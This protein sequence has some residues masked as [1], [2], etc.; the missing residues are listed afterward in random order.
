MA[1][2]QFRSDD[3]IK[4][5]HGFGDGHD[6]STYA[7]P[8]MTGCSG[9]VST[10]TLTLEAASTF[11]NNDLILILQTRGT[12]NLWQLNKI[13]SGAGTTTLTLESDLTNTYSNSGASQAQ[14]MEMKEYDGL[15]NTGFTIST[16]NTSQYG[17]GGY[18]DKAIHTISGT[19]S[20]D[21]KG[22]DG[23][24]GAPNSSVQTGE[25]H[26]HAQ[27][28]ETTNTGGSGGGGHQDSGGGGGGN[29]AAGGRGYNYSTPNC[30]GGT[31]AGTA[32]LTSFA[33]G[34]GGGGGSAGGG[35]GTG[36]NG[37]GG[38]FIFAKD[39]VITGNIYLRGAA[40][41]SGG[42]GRGGGGGAGGSCLLKCETATLGSALIVATG[43]SGGGGT[44]GVGGAGSTG[45]VHLDYSKSY[46]GTTS[47]TLDVTLDKTVKTPLSGGA[48]LL[49]NF[50]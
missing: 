49:T 18:F 39:L 35:S 13:L 27:T 33:L 40:G 48:L 25:G 20:G 34:G 17:I 12:H 23:G 19:I 36:G 46:T 3:T 2:L 43:G 22:F 24:T 29:A 41:T 47:P 31:L 16:W 8:A 9:T 50:T 14:V 30:F 15:T 37:G 42:A 4:W 10:K 1:Q 21:S 6:G 28:T 11:A 5:K 7:V 38:V 26:N 44:E 45:R 32:A